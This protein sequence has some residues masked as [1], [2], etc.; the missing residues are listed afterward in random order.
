MLADAAVKC[1]LCTRTVLLCFNVCILADHS[2]TVYGPRGRKVM[3]S[4]YLGQGE[5]KLKGATRRQ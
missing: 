1:R 2:C 3:A 4:V 5:I